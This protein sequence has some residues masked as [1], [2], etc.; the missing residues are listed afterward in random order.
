MPELPEVET[1]RRDLEQYL[2]N[3]K[4]TKIIIRDDFVKKIAP[5]KAK[6]IKFLTGLTLKGVERVGKMMIFDFG[7][8][9]RV[10][11]HMKMTGQFVFVPP[12][13]SVVSGGHPVPQS[14]ETPDRFNKVV[15]DFGRYGRLYYNDMRKFGYFQLVTRDQV[16]LARKKFG[17]E[18]VE[19]R[20][21]V[22]LFMSILE[23]KPN[24][25]IK[26]VLLMQE[27]ISGIGN[28]YADES[29]FAA[30]ILPDRKIKT[31]TLFEKK[32][33]Y[34]SIVRILK[35]AIVERGTSVNTYVDGSGKKGNYV[36]FLKVYHRAGERCLKCKKAT[37]VKTRVA[38]RGTSYCPICQK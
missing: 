37:I 20:F 2:K 30:G 18:P 28:I 15:I 24:L 27:L 10:L 26:K 29:C 22:K 33:L 5:S 8:T 19:K 32:K 23:R 4:I 11:A 36:R 13:G 34:Q 14:R 9:H 6:F 38:G 25:E 31:I 16:D 35:K 12:R 3:K 21:T 1:V 7:T 17:P